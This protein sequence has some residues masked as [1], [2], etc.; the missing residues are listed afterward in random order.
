MLKQITY[1]FPDN[2]S[3]SQRFFSQLTE[4]LTE[5]PNAEMQDNA[6]LIITPS[7]PLGALPTTTFT[8]SNI[9]FPTLT[10]DNYQDL[11]LSIGNLHINPSAAT[12]YQT[13]NKGFDRILSKQDS[14]GEYFELRASSLTIY[15]LPIN[16]LVTRLKGHIVRIDH[17]GINV[18]SVLISD[19]QWKQ[20]IHTIAR[21][22]NLY[23][24]PT[25]NAWPFILPTTLEEHKTDI[26]HFPVGREPK[27]E[28]V[29][30]TYSPVPTIQIDIETDLRRVEVER[31]FAAPYGISFPDLADYFRTV[32]VH[33]AWPGLAIRFDI[34]FKSDAPGD[35]ETGKWLVK[36]G[37]RI[38]PEKY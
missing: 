24:Y 14:L 30:D 31:L 38:M 9:P 26:T 37:G 21:Y 18:P 5:L 34:R 13:S 23:K 16:E 4:L 32:Y 6:S 10:L 12:N 33:H 28:L 11:S 15:R 29:Y 8:H 22:G 3:D 2:T 17:T 27:L 36:D 7:H 20:F 25:T 35:W 19:E 1:T